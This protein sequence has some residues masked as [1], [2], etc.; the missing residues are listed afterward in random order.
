MFNFDVVTVPY[1]EVDND[2][3]VVEL[4]PGLGAEF[5]KNT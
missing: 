1:A 2:E 5:N 3:A 4:F